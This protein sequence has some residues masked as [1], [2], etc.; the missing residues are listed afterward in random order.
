MYE[1]FVSALEAE[2]PWAE[3]IIDRFPVARA[4]RD[5]AD[6]GRKQELRRLTRALPKAEYAERQGAL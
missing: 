1:G 4:S 5:G 3:I 2:G 6:T